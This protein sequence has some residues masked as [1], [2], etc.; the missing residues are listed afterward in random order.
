MG[1]YCRWMCI[2]TRDLT[3]WFCTVVTLPT[4]TPAMR[5]SALGTSRPVSL[6]SALIRYP[7]ALNGMVPPN[8]VHMNTINPMQERVK[9]GAAMTADR[10]DAWVTTGARSS[11]LASE[12]GSEQRLEQRADDRAL[13][14]AAGD[15]EQS[16]PR[17][18]V[19]V[20]D[21]QHRVD[22]VGEVEGLERVREPLLEQ[23]VEAGRDADDDQRDQDQERAPVALDLEGH[24]SAHPWLAG[25][26]ARTT[27]VR[28]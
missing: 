15:D 12:G 5:T 1:A 10:L 21:G 20:G 4:L 27:S 2:V 25:L 6:N 28:S 14:A 24:A 11:F 16:S 3:P 17:D 23:D 22:V 7:W 18:P 8:C 26:T 19:G 9:A 13:E